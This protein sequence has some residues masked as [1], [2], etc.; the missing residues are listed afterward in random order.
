MKVEILE[1]D[2]EMNVLTTEAEIASLELD[3]VNISRHLGAQATYM[4]R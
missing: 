4:E 1:R 3:A 2:F